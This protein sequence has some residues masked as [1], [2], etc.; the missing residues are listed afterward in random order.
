MKG[1]KGGG[2]IMGEMVAG[3]MLA[4]VMLLIPQ[5]RL[6]PDTTKLFIKCEF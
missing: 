1:T 4:A 5:V 2:L 3:L 6:R